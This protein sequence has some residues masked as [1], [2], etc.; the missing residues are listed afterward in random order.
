MIIMGK[1]KQVDFKKFTC[2]EFAQKLLKSGQ[3]ILTK[4]NAFNRVNRE[5]LHA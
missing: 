5:F 1:T 4:S 2:I 3:I